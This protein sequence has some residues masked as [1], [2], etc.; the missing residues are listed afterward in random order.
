LELIGT[1]NAEDSVAA[2]YKRLKASWKR[3]RATGSK[4]ALL[5]SSLSAFKSNLLDFNYIS[6]QYI[7]AF[8]VNMV[9]TALYLSSPILIKRI[10]TFL[11]SDPETSPKEEGLILV[12]LLIASQF[13][14]RMIDEH[15]SRYQRMIG[16][17]STNAMVALIYSKELKVS[18]ATNKR[19]SQ[20]EI[21]NFVQVDA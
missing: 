21:V 8:L 10:I 20:G 13:I 4:N 14:S 9:M 11:E 1:I 2:S 19:F 7:I 6:G 3:Q 12:G 5:L 15:L 16:V 18:S 17:Q